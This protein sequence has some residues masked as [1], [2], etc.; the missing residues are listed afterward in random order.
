M[1][2]NFD[3]TSTGTQC[4]LSC[5]LFCLLEVHGTLVKV[6]TVIAAMLEHHQAPTL[7]LL[8]ALGQS[9]VLL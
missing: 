9:A 7:N 8:E 1:G 2:L 4:I 3:P 5:V 6:P